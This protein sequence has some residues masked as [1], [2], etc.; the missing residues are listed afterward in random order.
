MLRR[1]LARLFKPYQYMLLEPE[2]GRT[3]RHSRINLAAVL[4]IVL[5]IGLG[6]GAIAW[7]FAPRQNDGLSARYYQLRRESQDLR[8]QLATREGELAV[9]RGQIDALKDELAASQQQS[10]KLKQAQ[11]VYESILQARKS[12]GVH[13]LRA[14]AHMEDGETA[15]GVHRLFYSIVL[16]KGGNYPRTVSGSLRITA[17]GK[18]GEKQLLQLGKKAAELPYVMDTQTFLEGSVIWQ[19]DW[20]PVTL[21]ISRLDDKGEERDQMDIALDESK[22]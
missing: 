13:L 14:S 8:N 16:V 5:C 18:D 9:A 15:R 20:P 4:A 3:V 21:H 2:G 6:S 17:L 10:E 1:S 7:Y 12:A 22:P 19:Q 11:M